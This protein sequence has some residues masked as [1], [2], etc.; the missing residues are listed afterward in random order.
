MEQ[1]GGQ[2]FNYCERIN[3]WV[4]E[5]LHQIEPFERAVVIVERLEMPREESPFS[6]VDA[7][8]KSSK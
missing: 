6:V 2:A 4:K 3:S 8:K 1:T 7:I 5:L